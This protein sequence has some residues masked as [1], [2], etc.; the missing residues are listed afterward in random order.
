MESS[1]M[2][3][4]HKCQAEGFGG[5]GEAVVVYSKVFSRL[6]PGDSEEDLQPQV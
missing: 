4:Y 2:E 3:R 5:G 1:V 6:S